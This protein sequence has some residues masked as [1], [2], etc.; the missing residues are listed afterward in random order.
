MQKSFL[1]SFLLVA[2]TVLAT[3]FGPVAFA[4]VVTSGITG[5]VRS[6]DGKIISGATVTAVHT[7]TNATFHTTS[8]SVGRYNFNGLPVGG[9]YTVTSKAEGYTMEPL[10][11]VTTALGTSIDVDLTVKSEVVQLEKFV[12]TGARNALDSSSQG[13]AT[14]LTAARL[15]AKPT[16]QRSLA[17]LISASPTITLRALSGDREEAMITAVGQNNRYNSIMIDGN[18]INDQFGLNSTGLASFFNPLD[19]DTLEQLSIQVAPYD[20][21]YSG[22]TGASINAVT[23]SGTNV[24]KGSAYFIWSGDHLAGIQAQGPDARTYVQS[25]AK[26]IPKLERT[27]KGFTFGGPLWK[28][29]VFFFMNWAK[30]DRIGAPNAAGLPGVSATDLA[31]INARV[32]AITKVHFGSLGGNAN[33]L[34][35]DEKKTLKLDWNINSD[36][37][38]SLRYTTTEGEVPQFGSFTTTSSGTGSNVGAAI[39]G[40]AATAFDSHFYAQ[41][42]KEKSLSAQLFSTWTPELKTELKWSHVKQDQYT[43]TNSIAPEIDIYGVTGTNQAGQTVNNGV[44]VLGTERFRHGNQINVDTKNYSAIGEYARG[45][46][47]FSGGFDME[48]NNYYNLFRQYSYGVFNYASP[49]A[50]ANDTVFAF[51]RDF[52]D[53]TLKG[54]SNSSPTPTCAMMERSMEPGMSRRASPST[55]PLTKPARPRSAAASDILSDAPLGC[56]SQIPTALP[57]SAPSLRSS[58]QSVV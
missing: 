24:F 11:D 23:K 16:T 31:L 53:L 49:T 42:R 36:Q 57:A 54:T 17:D 58:P 26:V 20:T 45:N 18:R 37:R 19:L 43:P 33:S 56:S 40:G 35:K 2:A 44:V 51:R 7:P 47:T 6:S 46:L 48:D 29:H 34:A 10:T 32:A 15:A 5:L 25:G 8:N 55:T 13:A 12:A 50:F 9:P 41:Q 30:F 14:L 4:Q 3:T 1:K 21:R 38:L 22:F 27:T 52:T 28:D 39:V